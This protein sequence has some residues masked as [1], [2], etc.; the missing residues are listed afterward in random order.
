MSVLNF[1]G[2][3]Y[4]AISGTILPLTNDNSLFTRPLFHVP[5]F[6][7]ARNLLLSSSDLS[8]SSGPLV[9]L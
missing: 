7:E 5:E 6:T 2:L 1:S 9:S 8:H 3:K 4:S